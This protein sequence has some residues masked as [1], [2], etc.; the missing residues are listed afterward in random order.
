MGVWGTDLFSDDVACDVRDHYREL[1]EDGV[2]DGAAT[3]LTVEKFRAYLEESDGVALLA[4]AVTQSKLGRLDPRHP[5][6]GT[7]RARSGCRPRDVGARKSETASQ[8]PRDARESPRTTDRSATASETPATAETNQLGPRRW[9]RSRPRASTAR[10]HSCGSCAC[11]RI[12]LAKRR[13]SKSWTSRAPRCR[14]GTRSNALVP[15]S[16]TQ[17]PW[18]TP[19]HRTRGS[20]HSSCS[21]SIGSVPVSGRCRRSALAPATSRRRCQAPAFRGLNSPSATAVDRRSNDQWR[22]TFLD[23]VRQARLA[24]ERIH[25]GDARSSETRSD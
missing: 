3:R 10:E 24:P 23:V 17:S 14:H 21:A 9:R 6:S 13:C 25:Q 8:A 7:G 20:S 2:E 11:V 19:C 16:R 1:L 12:G 18:W 5:R 22:N 4:F 15:K